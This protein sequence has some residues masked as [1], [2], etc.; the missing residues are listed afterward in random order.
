MPLQAWGWN[1]ADEDSIDWT[2]D[3]FLV[4]L[5]RLPDGASVYGSAGPSLKQTWVRWVK[6][7]NKGRLQKGVSAKTIY[8]RIE[9]IQWILWLAEASG[10]DAGVIDEAR[11]NIDPRDAAQT[12][13]KALRQVLTWAVVAGSLNERRSAA[14]TTTPI[15]IDIREIKIRVKDRTTQKL[16][17]DAR[18]GQGQFRADLEKTWQGCCAVTGCATTAVL[19]AS[20][21]KPWSQST[22]EERLSTENG[23]LLAAHIDALFDRGLITF[24]DDGLMLVSQCVSA[25]DRQLLGLRGRLRRAPTKAQC[26]L[27]ARHRHIHRFE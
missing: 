2:R 26:Q 14:P 5:E 23:L 16:L 24:A 12:Q 15:L 25:Q 11:R 19:R 10:I 21:I 17:I 1:L 6:H 3:E 22:D 4:A 20:H 9:N 13:A 18:L 27:L 7:Y 8:N